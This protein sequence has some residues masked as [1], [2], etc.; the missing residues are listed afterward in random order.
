[1]DRFLNSSR[2]ARK[3]SARRTPPALCLYRST[4]IGEIPNSIFGEIYMMPAGTQ[5]LVLKEGTRRER[6]KGAQFNNIAAAKAVSGAGRSTLC[7][8]GMDTI[9]V[10]TLGD[11]VIPDAL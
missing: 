5:I 2:G 11:S 8:G 9:V 6:G 1:M 3:P 4:N 7:P 10:D